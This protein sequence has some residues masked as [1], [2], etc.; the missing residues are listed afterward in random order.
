VK[1]VSTHRRSA[2]ALVAGA[3]LV[4]CVAAASAGLVSS[5]GVAKRTIAGKQI[6]IVVDRGGDAVYELG[7]ESL[8]NLKCVTAQCLKIWTPVLVRSAAVKV[9]VATGV[10]GT[11]STLQRVKAKL[12]QVMLDHHPLYFYSGDTK[13]G[14][15]TG[16]GIKSFGGTWHVVKAG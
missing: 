16:Q 11:V 4:L 3:A 5:L 6:S 8:R 12:F 7:G 14:T 10:P 1:F 13:I 15:V 9:P 2:I